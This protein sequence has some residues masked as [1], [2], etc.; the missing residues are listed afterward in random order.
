MAADLDTGL[1]WSCDD[2]GWEEM[3]RQR[4]ALEEIAPRRRGREEG[5][6]IVLDDSD[7]ETLAWTAA[8]RSSNPRQGCSKYGAQDE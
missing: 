3:E 2:Y 7:E 6:V 4:R 5:D 1:K 8:V